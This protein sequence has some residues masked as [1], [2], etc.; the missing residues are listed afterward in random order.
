[1][2]C[3]G[4]GFAYCVGD[5]KL[6][7][8]RV[9]DVSKP[10]SGKAMC[11]ALRY[12]SA[13]L[14]LDR[15]FNSRA[16]SRVF[17]IL[18]RFSAQLRSLDITVDVFVQLPDQNLVV[19]LTVLESLVVDEIDGHRGREPQTLDLFQDAPRLC[20]SSLAACL[21]TLR[22]T[23]LIETLIVE[24]I[25]SHTAEDMTLQNSQPP[26]PINL[27]GDQGVTHLTALGERSHGMSKR[28]H[29]QSETA[30]LHGQLLHASLVAP[31]GRA[32]ITCLES[33]PGSLTSQPSQMQAPASEWALSLAPTG[34]PGASYPDGN[35]NV[36]KSCEQKPSGSNFSSKPSLRWVATRDTWLSTGTTMASSK[37]GGAGEA[38][39]KKLT[40]SSSASTPSANPR[41]LQSTPVTFLTTLTPPI[42]PHADDSHRA[43]SSYVPFPFLKPSFL[44]SSTSTPPAPPQHASHSQSNVTPWMPNSSLPA[45]TTGSRSLCGITKPKANGYTNLLASFLAAVAGLNAGK[46]LENYLSGARAWHIL[47]GVTWVPNKAECDAF[48]RAAA[49][50]QPKSSHKKKRQP[51]TL[52]IILTILPHLDPDVPLDASV[53]SCLTTCFYSCGR[54]G[55]FTVKTL[56]SFDPS[57]HAKP[58][59]VREEVDPQGLNMTVIGVPKTKS[60]SDGDPR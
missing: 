10:V 48:L 52:E 29:I 7:N 20:D 57:S 12:V 46:T 47:H 49:A 13:F 51:Y 43:T 26:P 9:G 37:D 50:L 58:S 22:Q 5:A 11:R 36:G 1:M 41:A 23:P 17:V 35:P 59:D 31:T 24:L 60:R 33:M 6:E 27:F 38:L 15:S 2:A 19:C 42:T 3:P 55:E 8:D 14:K 16:M 54:V 25:N 32:Y 21:K 44:S 53:G 56:Q 28:T 40:M 45:M 34:A 39:M 18:P 4:S 30:K